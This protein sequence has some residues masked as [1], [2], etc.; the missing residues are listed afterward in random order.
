MKVNEIVDQAHRRLP[1]AITRLGTAHPTYQAALKREIDAI[2]LDL[3]IRE[4]KQI[5]GER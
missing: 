4:P 3:A 2:R 5:Y 1:R